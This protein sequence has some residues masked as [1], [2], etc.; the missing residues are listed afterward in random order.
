M[1]QLLPMKLKSLFLLLP[2]AFSLLMISCKPEPVDPAPVT[3]VTPTPGPGN[4][5]KLSFTNKAGGDSLILDQTLRYETANNDS[6]SI[7]LFKYYISNISFT[8]N[9]GNT[10]YETES[11]HLI[12]AA[13]P[14]S[15]TFTINNVPAGT[16]TSMNYMI[17]V[18]STRNVSGSQTGALDPVYGMFWTWNSGYIMA[19]LEGRSPSSPQSFGM[20]NFHIGGFAGPYAGQRWTSPS[21]GAATANVT[22]TSIPQINITADALEWFGSPNTIDFATVNNVMI[23][24][25]NSASIANNYADMFTVTSIQN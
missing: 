18:D 3:P 22:T 11:Y 15:W 2:A 25:A 5:I 17:G 4:A 20:V 13:D 14:A 19:K 1:F 21:F 9:L 8:D 7:Q 24:N 12:D 23:S 6:L 16:Y 10:W